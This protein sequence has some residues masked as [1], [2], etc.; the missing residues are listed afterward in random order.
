MI[1]KVVKFIYIYMLRL[2]RFTNKKNTLALV[3]KILRLTHSDV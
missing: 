2:L 1:I 3:S